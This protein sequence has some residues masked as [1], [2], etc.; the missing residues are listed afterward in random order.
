MTPHPY[1]TIFIPCY[2]VTNPSEKQSSKWKAHHDSG[3]WNWKEKVNFGEILHVS[4]AT[5]PG[6]DRFEILNPHWIQNIDQSDMIIK[7]LLLSLVT[8]AIIHLSARLD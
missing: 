4:W 3:H 7:C 2:P 8:Y 6:M 5:I 1:P